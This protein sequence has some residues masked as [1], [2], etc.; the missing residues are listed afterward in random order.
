MVDEHSPLRLRLDSLVVY[1]THPAPGMVA[2]ASNLLA[3]G[4]FHLFGMYVTAY[5][6]FVAGACLGG[7]VINVRT[8]VRVHVCMRVWGCVRVCARMCVWVCVWDIRAAGG[9]VRR[10]MDRP[11]STG[12]RGLHQ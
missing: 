10:S 8:C 7:V 1:L 3:M 5:C 2:R 9:G 6:C 11:V 4:D 12:E